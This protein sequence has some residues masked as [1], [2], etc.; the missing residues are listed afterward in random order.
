MSQGTTEN[1]T[2]TRRARIFAAIHKL[3]EVR[4]LLEYIGDLPDEPW[5]AHQRKI[6]RLADEVAGEL[7]SA[8]ETLTI[9]ARACRPDPK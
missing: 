1:K 8:R 2:G 9:A 5:Q 3:D 4:D 6:D 7:G